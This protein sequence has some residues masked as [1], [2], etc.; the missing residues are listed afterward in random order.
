[1]INRK[2]NDNRRG[3]KNFLAD[4]KKFEQRK[5]DKKRELQKELLGKE[6]IS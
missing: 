3:F 1:V 5:L 6:G 2:H 4:L